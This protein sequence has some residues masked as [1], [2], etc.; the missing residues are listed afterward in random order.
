M[1]KEKTSIRLKKIMSEKGLK[2][3]DLINRCKPICER[4]NKKYGTNIKITKSDLSQWLKGIYEPSQNK[5]VILAEAL[6]TT[7]TWLMG[8]DN[9]YTFNDDTIM[10]NKERAPIDNI[11]VNVIKSAWEKVTNDVNNMEKLEKK[12]DK[13]TWKKLDLDIVDV[14]NTEAELNFG[15]DE[16]S[17]YFTLYKLLTEF[18]ILVEGKKASDKDINKAV[19]FI[20]NNIDMLKE[21]LTEQLKNH[22][23]IRKDFENS[24]YY[25]EYIKEI[26]LNN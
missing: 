15:L 8:Y 16:Y 26:E 19:A 11:M 17:N 7:E 9:N 4:Y 12:I 1:K 2:Q 22:F 21:K 6:N 23:S 24:E 14:V 5:L 13:E 18:N 3:I 25:D 20:T 10:T